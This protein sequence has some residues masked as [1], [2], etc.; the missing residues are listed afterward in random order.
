MK[1]AVFFLELLI[2]SKSFGSDKSLVEMKWDFDL[3]FA[4]FCRTN[5]HTAHSDHDAAISNIDDTFIAIS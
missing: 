2:N 4:L 1:V 3:K 5:Q